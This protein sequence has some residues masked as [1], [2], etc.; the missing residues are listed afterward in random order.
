MSL[1][2]KPCNFPS[3]GQRLWP[4]PVWVVTYMKKSDWKGKIMKYN[5]DEEI[6]RRNTDSIKWDLDKEETIPMWVADMDF[7]VADAILYGMQKRLEQGIFGYTIIPDR[8]YDA[9]SYWWKKRHNFEIERTWILPTIGVIPALSAIVQAFTEKGDKVIINSPVYNY[10]NTSIT[11]NKCQVLINNLIYE[12]NSYKI[13]FEDF[14]EKVSDEKVKLFILCNP[15]NP[16]GRVWNYN[17]LERIGEIC[18]KHKVIIVSDEIHRDLVYKNYKYTPMASINS[19]I[20]MNTITCTAPSKTFNIAGLK[21]AN[22]VIAN[23]ELRRK[24]DKALNINES[25][26]PNIF[27]IEALIAAYNEG[28]EWL[29]QL[30]EYLEENKIFLIDY[31]ERNMPNL[32]VMIPEGTYLV[33]IDCSNL[34]ISSREFGKKLLKEEKLRTSYGGIYGESG[35][36]FIRINIACTRKIM[37]EG[38]NRIFKCYK[39]L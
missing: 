10:F 2:A 15:H 1:S 24:V 27:G 25:S 9:E 29:E 30:L 38:L 20:L 7:K 35:K 13:D 31:I 14:E 33:W 5:F 34:S 4:R 23:E 8:Y 16:G 11:N 21:I 17:E 28:E 18:L 39:S 19:E 37:E 22:I 26:K 3:N 6:N 32:K 12:G 36:N